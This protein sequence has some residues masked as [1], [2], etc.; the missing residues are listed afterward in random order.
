MAFA[1]WWRLGGHIKP[2]LLE[3]VDL[4]PSG[5]AIPKLLADLGGEQYKDLLASKPLQRLRLN[6]LAGVIRQVW[7]SHGP[8]MAMPPFTEHALMPQLCEW[9]RDGRGTVV[10]LQRGVQ[11]ARKQPEMSD[12][13]SDSSSTSSSTV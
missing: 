11:H 6:Q 2:N 5:R 4:L 12:I 7:R 9:Q 13:S 10:K 1:L 3:F 8:R